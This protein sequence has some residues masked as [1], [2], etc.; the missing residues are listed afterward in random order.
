MF[1]MRILFLVLSVVGTAWTA[2]SG[3]GDFLAEGGGVRGPRVVERHQSACKDSDW[4]FCSDEDWNY[5]CPSGCR[6]KGLIDEVNQDF[7]NRINKLKNSLFEYQKNNKDSNSLTTNIMEILRGDFSSA[8]NRDNTYNRVSEDLRSRIEVLKRKVIEKVQHIQL[9]QKNVRAQLVDMKRLEVDID[10]KIRSCRGSCSR[11]LA[12]EVDLKDYEDQQKQLEQVIAK[13]LLPSRDRQH[14]PL[15]KMKPVPDLVPGNFKSQLNKA[16]PEWRALTDMPQMRMELERPGRNEVTRGDSTSYGTGSETE[17][18]RNPSS[19][20]SWSPGS[21]GPGS[22]GNR[23]PGSSGTGS[24]GT[25]KPGS[26]GSG[27]TGAWNSGSSGTVSTGNQNPGS[28]RP[29]S[30]GTWN[31][32]SSGHGSAGH[33]SSE[34]SVSGSTGHWHSESGS[35]RP[36]SSGSGNTRPTNPDWGTFEE[37]SGNVSP[38]TKREYHTDKL[39]TSKGDEELTTGKEKVTSGS[40]TTTRRSCSK[41]VTKTVIGPDGHKEVTKEVVT[42]EDGSDCPEGIDLGTLS[43]IGT[44]DEFR[45]RH[46]DEAAFFETA[47]TGKTFPGFF[48]PM[49]RE[50]VSETESMGSESGI[51]TNTKESSSRH[52]GIAEFP[53]SGKT[54]SHSKQF[55]TSTSYNREGS[56][57]ESKSYK[58][59]DE[60]GS[61]ADHEGT[62]STKRGHA[63]SRPVRDCDDVLQTHPSGTQSGIF[64]IK[65]PGSSKIFSVYCDQETSLGGWL[66]IQQ[67]MDGS[68]N[69]NRTW[70]DY[71][72]GFGSLNDEGEGEFWLGNDY[73]HLLT[74]R[75][76]VLR[77]E[78]EDWAGNE[79][80]AEYHFRVGSEAEGYALQVSSYE[81]TAGD[82]LIEGSVEEG[83]EY[84]S[85]N[86]MQFSTFDRDADQWEENCAE[87]YGGGWWYNNCQAANLN[88]IYY[89]GG[90]YDPRNNSPYEIENGVV[91]VSFRGADYSLRAVR[92]KIRPPVTQ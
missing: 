21:S 59:A 32:S 63:K 47:S 41:T 65:L 11:A 58:M 79:A 78:L 19:A 27:S 3:E 70:Q 39:V 88:G 33:W 4:P 92:M 6:M 46:P 51:F 48:S 7:T 53:S 55:I 13:D 29:G 71:K 45:H 54:S 81:G 26:S 62:H 75:G 2:D 72:R 8:N 40:T 87:V 42:S 20:G 77:V 85:H 90:S 28:P 15:I 36:D 56:T 35:F 31:P 89:L 84:T 66:L 80:Y 38:G 91:W 34:S 73:L 49:F 14:L 86:N 17:S 37:V 1:S 22:T 68:L 61:E 52:P 69:F 57:F 83:T 50:F 60:A 5:K 16:P 30:T 24:T 10:I 74:Q 76:S 82:A 18:P 44:L 25:W 43:G 9:L 67:R 23:N 64:N 12:R